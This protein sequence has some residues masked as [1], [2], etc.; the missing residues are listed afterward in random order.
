MKHTQINL[1]SKNLILERNFFSRVQEKVNEVARVFLHRV[2]KKIILVLSEQIT[3]PASIFLFQTVFSF[4]A[5]YLAA[6]PVS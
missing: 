3:L 4:F 6:G 1:S 5:V 2:G